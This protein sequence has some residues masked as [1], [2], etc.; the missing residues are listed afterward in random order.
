[1]SLLSLALL[2]V[3]TSAVPVVTETA[4][5]PLQPIEQSVVSQTNAQRARHGLPPLQIDMQLMHAARRHAAWMASRSSLQHT[6]AT[7]AENIA[8]GQS[9]SHEA[10]RDWMSSPGHRANILNHGYSRIGVGAYRGRD[11][12]IYWCQQFQW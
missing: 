12:Q 8:A 11:G 1:M 2:T 4:A 9:S 6:T 5:T 7:V 3:T 10:V